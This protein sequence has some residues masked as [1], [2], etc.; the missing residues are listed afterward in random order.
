MNYIQQLNAFYKKVQMIPLSPSSQSLY[1]FLLNK[2]NE[3]G[4]IDKFKVANSIVSRYD[5]TCKNAII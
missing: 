2:N 4:W 3:L 1:C 5:R